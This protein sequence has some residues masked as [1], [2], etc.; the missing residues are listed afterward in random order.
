MRAGG[1]CLPGRTN[2]AYVRDCIAGKAD[3]LFLRGRLR[4]GVG[5]GQAPFTS[6]LVIW[7]GTK[8]LVRELRRQV[9]AHYVPA[10][11]GE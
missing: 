5:A 2:V 11:A 3:V 10:F 9:D 4:F 7:G 8:R 1:S 6:M